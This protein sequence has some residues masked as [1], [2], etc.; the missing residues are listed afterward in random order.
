MRCTTYEMYRYSYL[1]TDAECTRHDYHGVRRFERRIAH[2]DGR[3]GSSYA[4]A[5]ATEKRADAK[6]TGASM[7]NLMG[8][9]RGIAGPAQMIL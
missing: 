7:G 6:P 1:A 2:D 5:C 9:T 4:D 3:E 8:A